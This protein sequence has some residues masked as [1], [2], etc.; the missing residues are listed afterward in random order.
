MRKLP[1]RLVEAFKATLEE[2]T[3]ADF[4]IHLLDA[5]A[6]E[7]ITFHQT[8]LDVLDEL[9]AGSRPMITVF[10]KVD[11]VPDPAVLH[12]LRV[13]FPDALFISVHSGEGIPAL[14]QKM[15]ELAAPGNV[16]RELRIPPGE[17]GLLARLHREA[18]VHEIKYD[19]GDSLV[20]VT[21]S[22]RLAAAC[23]KYVQAPPKT[24]G[25]AKGR[26]VFRDTGP[27]SSYAKRPSTKTR[28]AQ[29]NA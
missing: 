28:K 2:A 5:S 9:G 19:G 17:S 24:R 7:V 3:Q 23:A 26:K 21:L 1:H 25:P 27:E 16:T 22:Q 12:R 8:T 4:L 15:T 6:P 29:P 18:Q 20:T 13:H 14:L 11:K 10:N